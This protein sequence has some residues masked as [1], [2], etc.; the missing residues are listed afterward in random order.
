MSE[1][2]SPRARSAPAVLRAGLMIVLSYLALVLLPN[3]LLGYLTTRV[4][5]AWRD[6]IVV[7]A[8]ALAFLVC[9]VIFVRLQRGRAG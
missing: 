7:S 1:E 8:W 5:P 9:C 2:N 3:T 6:V 4:V